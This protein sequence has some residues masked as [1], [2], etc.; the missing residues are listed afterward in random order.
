MNI[1]IYDRTE[2]A[3]SFND[4]GYKVGAEIGVAYGNYSVV[5]CEQIKDLKLYCIDIWDLGAG[6]SRNMKIEWMEKA[7]DR[8]SGYNTQIIKNYSMDAVKG[9]AN[10]SLDFVYIDAGHD[11]DDAMLDIIFWTRKVRKGG[12]VAGHDY[13]NRNV[14]VITAVDGYIKEHSLTLQVTREP[15]EGISWFF[16]KKWN[17]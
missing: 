9:F 2:L 14:A 6:E 12:I 11:F 1:K 5:L 8:L 4:R 16:N 15:Q 13:V 10:N 17:S 7:K 3:R